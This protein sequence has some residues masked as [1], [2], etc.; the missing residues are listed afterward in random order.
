MKIDQL[1]GESLLRIPADIPARMRMEQVLSAKDLP[2]CQLQSLPAG[3]NS[4][5]LVTYS[6][7]LVS[8]SSQ[9]SLNICQ[10]PYHMFLL[11]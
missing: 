5:H 1:E 10:V 11:T 6:L 4:S 7:H 3:I 8:Y 2:C 9:L